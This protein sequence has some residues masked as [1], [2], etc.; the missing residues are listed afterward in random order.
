MDNRE[1]EDM[2]HHNSEEDNLRFKIQFSTTNLRYL[3]ADPNEINQELVDFNRN[4]IKKAEDQ[5]RA[6]GLID[7]QFQGEDDVQKV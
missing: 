7:P 2:G 1:R 4:E 6:M 5:L 3:L